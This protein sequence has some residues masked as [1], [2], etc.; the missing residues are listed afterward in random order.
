[1]KVSKWVASALFLGL[2]VAE[3]VFGQTWAGNIVNVIVGIN[4]TLGMGL[5]ILGYMYPDVIQKQHPV[6]PNRVGA[7]LVVV[8]ILT[9][10]VTGSWVCGLF[11][12][13]AIAMVCIYIN[14]VK[15]ATCQK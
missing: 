11:S 2:V 10:I 3:G 14:M 15:E 4:F 12:V 1:M 7:I 6:E 13:L 9:L 5:W 8:A